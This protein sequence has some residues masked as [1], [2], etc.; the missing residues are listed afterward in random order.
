[1]DWPSGPTQRRGMVWSFQAPDKSSWRNNENPKG[2]GIRRHIAGAL[3]ELHRRNARAPQAVPMYAKR[4]GD[5][6]AIT[7][8]PR[9]M[10]R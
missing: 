1:M 9:A 5:V 3:S 10:E 6:E 2:G 4:P 8:Y 7:E